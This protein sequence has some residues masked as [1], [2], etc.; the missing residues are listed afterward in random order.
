MIFKVVLTPTSDDTRISSKLS[1]TSSSTLDL[2]AMAL[3]N[4]DK[5]E[6]TFDGTKGLTIVVR[7]NKN[8]QLKSP[9]L[10]KKTTN[11]IEGNWGYLLAIVP[12]LLMGWIWFKNGR[13][14]KY[15]SDN[16]YVKPENGKEKNVSIFDRP[17]LPMVYAPIK[18][19]SPAEIGTIL[20]QK[21][22]T[23]DIVSEIIELARLGFLKIKKNYFFQNSFP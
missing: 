22:D 19:L 8:N 10:V 12:T 9:G 17:H 13:D 3:V 4:L 18:N 23:S 15:L 14:R 7:I 1:S 5:N 2:P 16:V 6:V 21:I 11:F 20:D